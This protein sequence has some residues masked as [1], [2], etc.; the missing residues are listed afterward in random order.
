MF[1]LID[2]NN[3][4]VSCE[5]VFNPSLNNKPVIVLSSND[6]CAIA[7]S[8]EAKALGIVMGA[9][10]HTFAHLIKLH[11]IKTLSCNFELYGD[12]SNRM[13]HILQSFTP[14]VDIYSID[15]AFLDISRLPI[16]DYALFAESIYDTILKY[17]GIPIT[18]G[19]APTKT[20]AKIANRSPRNNKKRMF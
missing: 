14:D 13:M 17:I 20:L 12:L 2:G 11:D 16:N 1:A 5:R 3:F 10:L 7:R 19:I 9:P 18:I 4:F 6:G 8:N 15:E